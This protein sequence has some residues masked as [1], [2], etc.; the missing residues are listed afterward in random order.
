MQDK[1]IIGN[2]RLNVSQRRRARKDAGIQVFRHR[3]NL[4]FRLCE[5]FFSDFY[6]ASYY[7]EKDNSYQF[8]IKDRSFQIVK[9]FFKPLK[10]LEKRFYGEH[11]F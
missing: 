6:R 10:P 4:A 11:C 7:G 1:D 3:E 5:T 2:K 9:R 8:A